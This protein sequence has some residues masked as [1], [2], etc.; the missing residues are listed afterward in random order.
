MIPSTL[1]K[2]PVQAEEK[3]QNPQPD[4]ESLSLPLAHPLCCVCVPWN[5]RGTQ[6]CHFQWWGKVDCSPEQEGLRDTLAV[7]GRQKG[8]R[9]AEGDREGVIKGGVTCKDTPHRHVTFLTTM[10]PDRRYNYILPQAAL[11]G[12]VQKQLSCSTDT[13]N[14]YFT[15]NMRRVRRVDQQDDGTGLVVKAKCKKHLLHNISD[16]NGALETCMNK[17]F[18]SSPAA[19]HLTAPSCFIIS[20]TV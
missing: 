12:S 5:I 7:M 1:T 6:P 10:L 11:D 16:A 14:F 8:D 18:V 19:L 17:E 13:Y 4:S 15:Y 3:T 9:E 2:A 20:Q